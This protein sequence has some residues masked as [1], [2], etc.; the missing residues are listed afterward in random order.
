GQ[1]NFLYMTGGA[2]LSQVGCLA[3]GAVVGLIVGL[4]DAETG[5]WMMVGGILA[6]PFAATLTANYIC[7]KTK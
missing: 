2:I 1:G 3:A 7:Y 5:G 6:L 4:L